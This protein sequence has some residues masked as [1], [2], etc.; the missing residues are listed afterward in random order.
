MAY[1]YGGTPAGTYVM[2]VRATDED[3]EEYNRKVFYYLYSRMASSPFVIDR[4][5]GDLRLALDITAG[6]RHFSFSVYGYNDASPRLT[7]ETIVNVTVTNMG[8]MLFFYLSFP[9]A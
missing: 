7:G 1:L 6:Q 8:G 5:T 2:R 4:E 3:F 9:R